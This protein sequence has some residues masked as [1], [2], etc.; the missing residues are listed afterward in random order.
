MCMEK[1]CNK[2]PLFNYKGEVTKLYC[3]KHKKMEW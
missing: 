1:N 2:I 3:S